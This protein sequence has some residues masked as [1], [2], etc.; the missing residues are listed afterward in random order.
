MKIFSIVL[1]CYNEG[2]NIESLLNEISK[3]IKLR[4]DL[5]IIIVENGSTD[6]SLIKIKNHPIYN[7]S[8]I[9]L[10][11]IKKNL[12][13]GYGI[14]KGLNKSTGKYIGWCHADLQ[15]NLTEIYDAFKKNLN[16]LEKTNSILKGKRLNR[17][18]IDNFF[19]IGMSM[20]VSILFKCKL[21]DINAQPKIFP[22][23]FLSLLNESPA[24]FSLDLYLLLTA[25]LNKYKILEYPF[26]VYKRIAGKAKGGGSLLTKFNLTLRTLN[27]IYKLKIGKKF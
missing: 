22:R 10:V 4:D 11:E 26:I 3:L 14:M 2:E 19:T 23:N 9:V 21:T 17:G 13:Y 7:N 8:S 16:T 24:D 18:M 12:G 27:Y 1:P 5:E 6:N 15:N 25:K 20:L